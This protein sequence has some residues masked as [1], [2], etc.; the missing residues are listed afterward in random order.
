MSITP[1]RLAAMI[2]H[3]NLRP[4]ATKQDFVRLC[5]EART[6]GFA[7]VAINPYPVA[8][9]A[10][11]LRGSGVHIGAAIGFPLGQVTIEDKVSETRNAIANGTDEIDY[12]INI[13]ELK[14][15]N[16]SYIEREMQAIVDVARSSAVTTK[17]IFE[18]CYLTD[19]EKRAVA[20][21]A[22]RVRPDFVKTS[23]GFG[24]RGA[25]LADVQLMK[26]CVGDAVQVKAA[27]GIRTLDAALS[28][29][30]AG[31]T[32]IGTSRGVDLIAQLEARSGL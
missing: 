8:Q 16:L 26:E 27:G 25:T 9:C 29:I 22:V 7:M 12:V 4:D 24:S 18:N 28:F 3:T 11:L 31:A 23:T 13:T 2:D 21:V 14:A 32:R 5:E 20:E 10:D 30:A 6:H 19:E 15:G 17:V 1:A